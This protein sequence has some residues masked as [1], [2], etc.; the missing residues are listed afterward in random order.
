ML[1]FFIAMIQYNVTRMINSSLKEKD[2]PIGRAITMFFFYLS[3]IIMLVFLSYQLKNLLEKL[4]DE[5]RR[6][7]NNL[8]TKFQWSS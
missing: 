4:E 5:E 7:G 8:R 2:D 1:I 3:E 6:G